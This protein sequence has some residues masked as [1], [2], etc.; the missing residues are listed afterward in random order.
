MSGSQASYSPSLAAMNS[1][2]AADGRG[3]AGARPRCD[4]V[5]RHAVLLHLACE[6][7]RH[8]RDARLG[9]G[10]VGLPDH[11]R[12]GPTRSTVLMIRP[13]DAR[14]PRLRLAPA[15]R[16]TRT[17]SGAKWPLR[18]TRMTA[19]QS[20]SVMLKLI[21]SRRMPALLT[22]MSSRPNASTAVGDELLRAGPR[23][24]VVA[25]RDG[26]AAAGGDLVDDLLRGAGRTAVALACDAEVVHDDLARPRRRAA[27]PRPGRCRGPRR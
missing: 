4:R 10:V 26:G 15:S 19:S 12:T 5:H 14:S 21:A 25:V 24:H 3:H 11:A 22:R 27:S 7:E 2:G 20:S 1:V 17:G 13:R 18:W 9:G 6:H 8:R 23:R 16:R